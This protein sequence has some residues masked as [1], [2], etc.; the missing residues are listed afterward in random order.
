MLI[1]FSIANF[2]SFK[3]K[4]I[5]NLTL[6]SQL[7]KVHSNNIF[8]TKHK[9]TTK[10]LKSAVLYGA[11]ASGKSNLI[12][13][14]YNCAVMILD[15]QRQRGDKIECFDPFLLDDKANFKPTEYA[16]DFIASNSIRYVYSFG[17]DAHKIHYEKLESYENE[18]TPT[19]QLIYEIGFKKEKFYKK[20]D[21]KQLDMFSFDSKNIEAFKNTKNNLFLNLS[22]NSGDSSLNP[23][24]DWFKNYAEA[25]F[26]HDDHAKDSFLWLK[27]TEN[28]TK[29]LELIK[30]FDLSITDIDVVEREIDLP[31]NIAEDPTIP[32]ELKNRLKTGIY[33][34]FI[35]K[36]KEGKE[37]RFKNRQIS[38]GTLNLITIAPQLFQILTNGGVLF[39][40]ELDR[41]IHPD[42]LVELVKMFHDPKYNKK[43]AQLIFTA[44][45][46]ILLDKEHNLFNHHQI[47]F[48]SKDDAD[49]S[50]QLY[51]LSY[52][53][54]IAK[55]IATSYRNHE[56]G[57]R[58]YISR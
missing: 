22:V 4:Q 44:H 48:V 43:N 42:I 11:N 30:K 58:P 13:G 14:F 27:E 36:T 40:D 5:I 46:D 52:F 50:S 49:Q 54:N 25:M 23:V 56:Y 32:Q 55:N 37:V 24:Y 31:L 18:K 29:L 2:R 1:S 8:K 19:K 41:S 47:W 21:I 33:P 16:I 51:C 28:K 34:F 39:F 53:E 12:K 26:Q 17:F 6:E 20:P 35:H 57:A 9:Q 45:N 10:L 7:K 15:K 38:E 3:G